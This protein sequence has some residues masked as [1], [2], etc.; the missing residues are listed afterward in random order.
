LGAGL[1]YVRRDRVEALWPLYGDE[2]QPRTGIAKLNHTGTHP[3][4][5]DLA[6]DDAITFHEEI[7]IQRKEARLR[8]LQQYWTTRVRGV[9]R[10]RLF[11]PSDPR[12]TGAIA[13]VGIDGMPPGE[14][15]AAL[16]DRFR[17]F[18]VAIDTAGVTGVR[19]TPQ[20]FTTTAELDALVRAL[21]LLAS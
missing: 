10:I 8:W 17:I 21:T 18:T 15:A 3:V 6:I 9:P 12:R 5:T 1:L 11:T 16:M 4:H 2:G 14:L 13:N 20:L 19:I 7:G